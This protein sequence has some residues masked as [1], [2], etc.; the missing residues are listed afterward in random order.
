MPTVLTHAAVGLGLGRVFTARPMPPLYWA[1]LA[2]LPMVPDVDVLA[3]TLGVPYEAAFGHRGFT[4]SLVFALGVA[5]G[6][7]ALTAGRVGVPFADWC[8][9]LFVA[10]ASHGILDA[11]TDGGLGIAFFW[12]FDDTRSFLPWRPIRVSP[13]GAGFFSIRGLD[14]LGSEVVWVWL[15]AAVVLGVV[16]IV[17]R[18]WPRTRGA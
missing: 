14:T 4:H 3:F 6:A 11:M 1:L 15:P 18:A 9:L 10:V 8:G 17:R 12:P 5:V 16:E 7:A 2:V 13:I